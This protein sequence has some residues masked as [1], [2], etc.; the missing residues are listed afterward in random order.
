MRCLGSHVS[1][2]LVEDLDPHQV[3]LPDEVHHERELCE[4]GEGMIMA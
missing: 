4:T 3:E 1:A 2:L